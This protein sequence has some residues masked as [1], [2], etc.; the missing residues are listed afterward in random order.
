MRPAQYYARYINTLLQS[1]RNLG[2]RVSGVRRLSASFFPALHKL[3]G[4][5][6]RVVKRAQGWGLR[7]E[8]TSFALWYSN[9][10]VHPSWDLTRGRL[11]EGAGTFQCAMNFFRCGM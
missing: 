7:E 3:Y 5:F 2:L 6:L 1:P 11:G 8:M 4:V 9:V 10:C